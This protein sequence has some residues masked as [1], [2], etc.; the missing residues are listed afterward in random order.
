MSITATASA[1]PMAK[2]PPTA[3]VASKRKQVATVEVEVDD[4]ATGPA[5][6]SKGKEYTDANLGDGAFDE[7]YRIQVSANYHYYFRTPGESKFEKSSL[8]KAARARALRQRGGDA[9]ALVLKGDVGTADG[10]SG[11]VRALKGLLGEKRL[12]LYG[13]SIAEEMGELYLK[14]QGVACEYVLGAKH[15]EMRGAKIEHI[16]SQVATRANV[17]KEDVKPK[18]L[19]AG[20][21]V[22]S[23]GKNDMSHTSP[24]G[25]AAEVRARVLMPVLKAKPRE[26][27]ML[28][29]T[30]T[31]LANCGETDAIA[32][33][34]RDLEAE[35]PSFKVVGRADVNLAAGDFRSRD[36]LHLSP[37]GM[38]KL[39][40]SILAKA[41]QARAKA[42]APKPPAKLPKQTASA[43][44]SASSDSTLAEL[45]AARSIRDRLVA[46]Q[47]AAER[48]GAA[49]TAAEKRRDEARTAAEAAAGTSKGAADAK[50]EAQEVLRA[51]EKR[52][53]A[54]D[55]ALEDS[56]DAFKSC[57][58]AVAGQKRKVDHALLEKAKWTK[59]RRHEISGEMD[60]LERQKAALA[61]ELAALS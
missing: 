18:L 53:Q 8:K 48:E 49:L 5:P 22:V 11:V 50:R 51:A 3:R 6:P 43:G 25:I 29:V 16:H 37:T 41:N 4:G 39:L 13:D 23:A 32:E 2:N 10:D 54:A 44:S 9:A 40:R 46:A 42:P 38:S 56:M 7:G 34:L 57:E 47:A 1:R 24:E 21:I 28:Y 61:A 59:A 17:L 19:S 27:P 26:L 15:R 58:Q 20:L 30:P 45:P 55:Q 31:K 52:D 35:H 14:Q 60:R 12:L 36:P 33:C